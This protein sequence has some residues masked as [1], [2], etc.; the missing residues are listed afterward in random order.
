MNAQ[1]WTKEI[2]NRN[3][4]NELQACCNKFIESKL[5]QPFFRVSHSDYLI[6][7]NLFVKDEKYTGGASTSTD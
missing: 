1:V 6:L 2:E 4:I 5:D 7:S 3:I